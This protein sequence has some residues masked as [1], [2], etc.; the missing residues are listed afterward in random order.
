MGKYGSVSEKSVL[1]RPE[2]V[3]PL[4]P[5][6]W[7]VRSPRAPKEKIIAIAVV[8]GGEISGRSVVASST[9]THARGRFARAAGKAERKP[10]PV[11]ASP[12]RAPRRRLFPGE[13]LLIR[14][15]GIAHSGP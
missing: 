4:R 15:R 7:W 6:S 9:A 8:N 5:R 3:K 12:T 10:S 1:Q 14:P 13:R 2:T 11:A